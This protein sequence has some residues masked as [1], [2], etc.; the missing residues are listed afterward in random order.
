MPYKSIQGPFVLS[1]ALAALVAGASGAPQSDDVRK[2]AA[3]PLRSQAADTASHVSRD[4]G[5][6]TALAPIE[7]DLARLRRYEPLAASDLVTNS[8][9]GADS[10][11]ALRGSIGNGDALSYSLA[12]A[13]RHGRVT[14]E[15]G[16]ATYRPD[17]DF[18]GVD[19][20]TYRVHAG[21]DSAEAVVAVT[22]IRERSLPA[23]AAAAL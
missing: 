23:T 4:G 20:Y 7:R 21:Q 6:D 2:Q 8:V 1:L 5:I 11:I 18:V 14:I 16:R 22:S 3:Q 13:P 19:T 10:T 15:N 12:V 17:P 9:D